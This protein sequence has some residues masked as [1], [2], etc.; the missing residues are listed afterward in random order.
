[1]QSVYL[2]REHIEMREH[3]EEFTNIMLEM[4]PETRDKY[5]KSVKDNG[6]VLETVIIED[7]FM[8][9]ILILLNEG[10]DHLLLQRIFSYFEE[11]YSG[12]DKYLQGIITVAALE[13][14]GNETK[15]L[16]TARKFMGPKTEE[17]QIL[18]D[19]ALGRLRQ[20]MPENT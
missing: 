6:T 13:S 20:R 11:I 17:Q 16:E 8:P 4:L 9:S 2:I 3:F 12:D 18:A 14:L 5:E 15:I 7:V 19:I 1:M 10:Y